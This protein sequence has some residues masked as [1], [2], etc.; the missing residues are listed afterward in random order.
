MHRSIDKKSSLIAWSTVLLLTLAYGATF[1]VLNCLKYRNFDWSTIDVANN[2]LWYDLILS[3]WW[4]SISFKDFLGPIGTPIVIQP[5]S[6]VIG[7]IYKLIPTPY[8]LLILQPVAVSAGIPILYLIAR[9]RLGNELAA[10][11]VAT[12][13][14][15]NPFI[16]LET[17][18]GFRY[19]AIAFPLVMLVC[20]SL[21]TNRS[22][23]FWAAL[24][25]SNACKIN[26]T[27][28]NGI[29]C[30]W[31]YQ[32]R[33]KPYLRRACLLCTVWFTVATGISAIFKA[34][35]PS[36]VLDNLPAFQIKKMLFQPLMENPHIVI[37]WVK[38][39]STSGTFTWL[40]DYLLPVLFLPLAAVIQL[41]PVVFEAVYTL[42]F[43]LIFD[44]IAFLAEYQRAMAAWGYSFMYVAA[45]LVCYFHIVS[46]YGAERISNY[47]ER[48]GHLALT[49]V[50]VLWLAVAGTY[51]YYRTPPMHGPVPITREFNWKY[52]TMTAHTQNLRAAFKRL[53]KDKTPLF[54]SVFCERAEGN[55]L[56]GYLSSWDMKGFEW[57]DVVLVDLYSFEFAMPRSEMLAKIDLLLSH[58]TFGVTFFEDGIIQMERGSSTELN[59]EVAAFIATHRTLLEHNLLNPYAFGGDILRLEKE[60][61]RFYSCTQL[62][63]EDQARLCLTQPLEVK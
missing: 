61:P 37:S 45:N 26:I 56:R 44:R 20:L 32:S 51:H 21:E 54:S 38:A 9:R 34:Y 14:A 39:Y 18:F 43:S 25:A 60:T 46:I 42:L 48:Y 35:S 57:F 13:Y 62:L 53:P 6:L 19:E 8:L 22:H 4:R 11:A 1:S 36:A 41:M 16:N 2:A 31:A 63:P 12:A 28:I 7:T 29:L 10:V 49:L 27:L 47:F 24:V 50:A 15:L 30:F 3:P 5:M 23:I 52:Y 59:G 55:F 33:K 40:V 17:L 58:G